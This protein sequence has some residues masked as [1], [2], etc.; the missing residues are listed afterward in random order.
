M[1]P[2]YQYILPLL[3]IFSLFSSCKQKQTELK[4]GNW[5]AIVKTKSDVEIPFNFLV[6]D[7]AGRK[8]IYLE[9]AKE[10]LRVN[11]ITTKED[12]VFIKLPLFDS[13]IRAELS[14]KLSGK[15]IKHLANRDAEMKFSAKPDINWRFFKADVK[16]KFNIGGR[17]SATFISDNGKDTTVAIGEFNQQGAKVTGTFLTTTGDYRFLEGTVS[18]NKLFLSSFDGASAYLF[19]GEIQDKNTIINGKFYSGYSG[20][21]SWT[22]KRD[23]KAMLPDPY[24]LTALK[25]GYHTLSFTFPNLDGKAV[26]LSDPQFKNK[27]VIV[28]FLGSWCPNCMDETA[29]LAPLYKKYKE[30]GLEIIGLA[31]ERTKNFDRSKKSLQRLKDRFQVTYPFLIT[32]YTNT[33]D[34]VLKSLPMLSDFKAFPTSVIINRKGVVEK[35]HT[36]FAGPGTGVHYEQFTEDFEKLI[37]ELLK[38]K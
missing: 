13:E 28:Q 17:W 29:Y 36:G 15:W 18:E 19:T 1:K 23:E 30:K 38:E 6:K 10:K 27:V 22:A 16:T 12:S 5:R 8:I 11:E 20:V 32:G 9:N 2:L 31:Y 33:K 34:E 14:N 3:L 26:S 24:S 25:P 4:A 35:I 7:S 21:K 37:N